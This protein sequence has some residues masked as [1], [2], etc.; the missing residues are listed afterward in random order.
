VNAF[1]L[2]KFLYKKYKSKIR[3]YHRYSTS[4][5]LSCKQDPAGVVWSWTVRIS[6]HHLFELFSGPLNASGIEQDTYT[7]PP[8]PK[9]MLHL[10]ASL[11][12]TRTHPKLL[13]HLTGQGNSSYKIL[14]RF[15][16]R[17]VIEMS[18]LESNAASI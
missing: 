13:K 10:S 12:R 18:L 3:A 4:R 17:C 15:V 1:G 14:S 8:I 11:W 9:H 16:V 7:M 5:T 2:P 6:V